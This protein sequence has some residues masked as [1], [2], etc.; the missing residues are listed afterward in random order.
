[1]H[2]GIWVC[3]SQLNSHP[4]AFETLSL[5]KRAGVA[6]LGPFGKGIQ[7]SWGPCVP[8][9][10]EMGSEQARP[11]VLISPLAWVGGPRCFASF[12]RPRSCIPLLDHP[13]LTAMWSLGRFPEGCNDSV[14]LRLGCPSCTRPLWKRSSVFLTREVHFE[15]QLCPPGS[16]GANCSHLCHLCVC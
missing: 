13:E 16:T 14:R 4:V 5:G 1:M 12:P 3:M 15:P 7:G 9:R 10:G 11:L 2:T 6:G 8:G